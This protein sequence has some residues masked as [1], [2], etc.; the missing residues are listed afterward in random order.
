MENDVE[1]ACS[2]HVADTKCDTVSFGKPKGERT[3][4]RPR[5]R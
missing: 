3:V 5:P 1:G 4:G 2:T